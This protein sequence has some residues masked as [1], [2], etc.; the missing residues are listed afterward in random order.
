MTPIFFILVYDKSSVTRA[1]DFVI[2]CR[3]L[4]NSDSNL[5]WV[6]FQSNVLADLTNVT[7]DFKTSFKDLKEELKPEIKENVFF[8]LLL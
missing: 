7:N 6:A 5:F 1:K 3:A 2:K 8:F 4:L